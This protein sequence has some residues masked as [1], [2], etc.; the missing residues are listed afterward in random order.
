MDELTEE[1]RARAMYLAFYFM[2]LLGMRRSEV[3][4][5]PGMDCHDGE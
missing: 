4:N 2:V 1:A 5:A 3:L